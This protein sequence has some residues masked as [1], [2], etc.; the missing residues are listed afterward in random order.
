MKYRQFSIGIVAGAGVMALAGV[1]SGQ[2]AGS[3]EEQLEEVVVTGSRVIQNGD[4]SPTPVTVVS[5][6]QL[7]TTTPR[8]V[9]EGLLQLPVFAGGRSPQTNPGNSSQNGSY[10]SLNLRNIGVTRTLVL[11][12][13]KRVMTTTPQGE[14]D[15]DFV[16][17]MLLQRV[18]IVT[19]GASA[20]Y[21]SD[22]ISGVVNF[23]TDRGYNGL[24]VN[25]HYGLSARNDAPEFE[26]GV[27]GGTDLFGGRGHLEGSIESFTS[28]GIFTKTGRDWGRSVITVNRLNGTSPYHLVYDTRLVS[29]SFGGYILLGNPA[30]NP[31]RDQ[32]FSSNGVLTPFRHGV[33]QSG[34][35]ANPSVESGGDGGYY[36]M[37]SMLQKDV[38]RLAFGRFDFDVTDD[39]HFYAELTAMDKH[40]ENNHQ[41]NEVRNW[42]IDKGNA[43]L[44]ANVRTTLAAINLPQ[45]S[46][47]GSNGYC[48]ANS[49]LFGKMFNQIGVLQ[50][51]ARI[52]NV[53][54]Q[55]ALEGKFA[56]G[57]RWEA[58]Y[59][60]TTGTQNTRNNNNIDNLKMAAASDAVT[61]SSGQIVCQVS[62]TAFASL[63]P[64]CVPMNPFGPTSE[65]QAMIDYVTT[66]T[67]FKATT[68]QH[69]VGGQITGAPFSS[70]A[71]PVNMAVSAEWRNLRYNV[72]SNANDNTIIGTQACTV[73]RYNCPYPT[74]TLRYV[75]NVLA[76]RPL[77]TQTVT[78]AAYEFD[79][80]LLADGG[81]LA[82]SLNL[83]GAARY[84]SYTNQAFNFA[85]NSNVSP[86]FNA[87]TWKLGLDWHL[88]DDQL[89]VRATRSRD[90][91][92]P[93]LIELFNPRLIN[94][95][96]VKDELTGITA[97]A[98]F[99]TDPN[100]NLVPE[101]ADT[102]T[103]GIVLHPHFL[104][105]FSLAVDWYQL[106]IGNAIT[107]L[108]GQ[109][110]TLQI[111]CNQSG[112]ALPY[113]S[114]IERPF[115]LV[116]G[117]A[118][119]TTSANFVTAFY[120]KPLNAQVTYTRGI[121]FE[122]NYT[123]GLFGGQLA[124]RALV[125]YQPDMSQKQIPELPRFNAA[126]TANGLGGGVNGQQATRASLLLKYKHGDASI[127]IAE[128]WASG[129][130]W[131][132]DFSLIYSEPSIPS[133][134]YTAMTLSYDS[135]PLNTQFYFSINNVFDEQP[136]PYGGIGGASG[137]PGLFGGYIPGE[138]LLGRYFTLGLRYR[139]GGGK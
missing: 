104:Q 97:S 17:S 49:F 7:L 19:G 93:N 99:I 36:N 50:P 127:D 81:Y 57:F 117:T 90:I 4:N 33:L 88:L 120:S 29:T 63:Y 113:C 102:W 35:A 103:A 130:W 70:W 8:T 30:S 123:H 122:A 133:K 37:A 92:A 54:L 24:K 83:N 11:F 20:V 137:V 64:G 38:H 126:G 46:T 71:G 14:V 98:P 16:P 73:L 96:G 115:P 75:S 43:Y 10:R 116:P 51:D 55:L 41:N 79:L 111:L 12:D 67:E 45:I 61:N 135:Q 40:N 28:P 52:R 27:A 23:V 85:T 110:T 34:T 132:P 94:P 134:A 5:T 121:D 80:P 6:E 78:E 87:Q 125:S 60:P 76:N 53:S 128:K 9:V 69:D 31:F 112:G 74:A 39:T 26:L 47:P 119:N 91:R 15:A 66:V 114:L 124:A 25:S 107:T 84:A 48:P 108:Q 13:G 129:V 58:F 68:K 65:T 44:P 109:N 100:P 59:V 62:T 77:V 95:A 101:K 136:T 72:D 22:A 2:N 131:N 105:N 138:D 139:S 3:S 86:K 21:G 32:T 106:R 1:A 118:P 56:N 82:K 42:C 18:D 89:T